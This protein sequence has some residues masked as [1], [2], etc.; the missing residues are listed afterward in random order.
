MIW[1]WYTT[2]PA[3]AHNGRLLIARDNSDQSLFL[4]CDEG[5]CG[6]RDPERIGDRSTY[7]LT[8]DENFDFDCPSEDEIDAAGWRKY[9]LR[10]H[11][12]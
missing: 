5:E 2:C 7:F 3:C 1:Y 10:V 8:L 11:N 6:W 12:K 9:C 4:Y